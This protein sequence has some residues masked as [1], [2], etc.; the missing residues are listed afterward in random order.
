MS[1]SV[2]NLITN[3]GQA[4]QTILIVDDMPD[5]IDLLSEVLAPYYR[6]RVALNG[7]KALKIAAGEFKPDLILLDIM[8]PG[9]SGYD[10]CQRLKRNSDTQGIPIIFVTA[11]DETADEQKGLELGA[12]DYITKP[13][14][15]P[16][17]LARVR[18]HLALYDQTR[19]L[20][21]LVALRTAELEKTRRQIIRRLGRA[22]EC[23][24]HEPLFTPNRP[25]DGHECGQGGTAFIRR[26]DARRGQN[27][28]PR[29]HYAK[30]GQA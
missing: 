25:S 11:M 19:E 17:V 15:P 18:T 5:N 10:V 22:A 1:N 14:S 2:S 21:R 9:I 16:L 3:P 12:V 6:T 28:H 7:E 20:E 30:T 26:T 23:D 29:Q 4:K 8:M 27:R 24:S 13:I